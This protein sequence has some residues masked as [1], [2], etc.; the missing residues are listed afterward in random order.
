MM[1]YKYILFSRWLLKSP[2]FVA[3]VVYLRRTFTGTC[4]GQAKNETRK[5]PL[6]PTR[7]FARSQYKL[8]G[9]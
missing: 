4:V 6:Y 8:S 9:W 2:D 1:K 3:D 7:I 5:A